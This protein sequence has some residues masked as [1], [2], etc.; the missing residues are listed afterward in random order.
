MSHV[1]YIRLVKSSILSWMGAIL[2][3]FRTL[4]SDKRL[5]HQHNIFC[6]HFFLSKCTSHWRTIF[7]TIF[8]WCNIRF[9]LYNVHLQDFFS[10]HNPNI[11][12]SLKKNDFDLP[13]M[14]S[15]DGLG[16]P[17][18]EFWVPKISREISW[19]QT[20]FNN[21]MPSTYYLLHWTSEPGFWLDVYLNHH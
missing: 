17:K 9:L 11:S 12:Q 20:L 8:L 18:M 1:V 4:K 5:S 14:P 15:S 6:L 3:N 16:H 19:R 21:N 2:S 7:Y 10:L 13:T